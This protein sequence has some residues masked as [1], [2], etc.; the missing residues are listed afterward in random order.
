MEEAWGHCSQCQVELVCRW[1]EMEESRTEDLEMGK[2]KE[3]MKRS[4]QS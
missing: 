4:K 2:S 3:A 1:S